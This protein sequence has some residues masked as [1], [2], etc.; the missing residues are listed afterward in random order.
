MSL[1]W[2]FWIIDWFVGRFAFK[3]AMKADTIEELTTSTIAQ[4]ISNATGIVV[5]IV[6]INVIQEYSSLERSMH[7]VK[8]TE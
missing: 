4:L 1:W 2:T 5:A 6:T 3:Y 7:K 8:I